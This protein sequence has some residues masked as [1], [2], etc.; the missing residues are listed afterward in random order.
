MG[1]WARRSGGASGP[2]EGRGGGNARGRM[3]GGPDGTSQ[4]LACRADDS[5]F[6][7]V[8]PRRPPLHAMASTARPSFEKGISRP[9][10][11]SAQRHPALRGG[12]ERWIFPRR[13]RRVRLGSVVRE[14]ASVSTVRPRRPPGTS[15]EGSCDAPGDAH[16]G[17]RHSAA[18][19]R[20]AGGGS[21]SQAGAGDGT[22]PP[23]GSGWLH[24]RTFP[25]RSPK[26]PRGEPP[27]QAPGWILRQSLGP[28]PR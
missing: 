5:A 23:S 22:W 9:C 16:Q 11:H 2:Q 21:C 13:L 10:S 20:R 6:P 28:L 4:R 17:P 26:L 7:V 14:S 27:A 12:A 18:V 1:A 8:A 24:A 15:R 3:C 19:R 25:P